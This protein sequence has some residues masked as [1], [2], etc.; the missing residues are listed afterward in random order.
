MEII[1]LISA[2]VGF[3]AV[4]GFF[5]M[6]SNTTD[7]KRNTDVAKKALIAIL[8]KMEQ[9]SKERDLEKNKKIITPGSK[10]EL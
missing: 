6:V 2:I 5:V 3:F 8:E 10:I 9:E 7:I 1:N 4:I